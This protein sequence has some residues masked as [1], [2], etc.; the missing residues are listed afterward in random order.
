MAGVRGVAGPSGRQAL[1]PGSRLGA[2]GMPGR[3]GCLQLGSN[4]AAP[5]RGVGDCHSV[6][7]LLRLHHA[8]AAGGK[9]VV[10]APC[11]D[12]VAR[13]GQSGSGAGGWIPPDL[14]PMV[15][16][17]ALAALGA[18]VPARSQGLLAAVG[19]RGRAGE[20]GGCGP[21][22]AEPASVRPS[23]GFWAALAAVRSQPGGCERFRPFPDPLQ[24][25]ALSFLRSRS[26][27][28]F[29]FP[30]RTA[31]GAATGW[32]PRD[33]GHLRIV[34]GASMA[35]VCGVHRGAPRPRLNGASGG[36][37]WG[38]D[39]CHPDALQWRRGAVSIRARPSPLAP[40]DLWRPAA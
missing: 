31:P 16:L 29:P 10:A 3:L 7:H 30:R 23:S 27:R 25:L 32:S 2:H 5:F 35:L 26:G 21:A 22:G 39:A 40:C 17:P 24:P 18:E 37:G 33:R 15:P 14:D 6:R 4:G 1:A 11:Q 9:P 34:G 28:I 38:G 8:A 12:I 20:H 13:R 19:R 36:L